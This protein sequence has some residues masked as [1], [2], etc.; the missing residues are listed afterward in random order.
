MLSQFYVDIGELSYKMHGGADVF[1]FAALNNILQRKIEGNTTLRDCTYKI[2]SYNTLYKSLDKEPHYSNIRDNLRLNSGIFDIIACQE[3]GYSVANRILKEANAQYTYTLHTSAV[4]MGRITTFYKNDLQLLHKVDGI[5]EYTDRKNKTD[6]RPFAIFLFKAKLPNLYGATDATEEFIFINLHNPHGHRP[7]GISTHIMA[8]INKTGNEAFRNVKRIIVAGDFNGQDI[9]NTING[10]RVNN[11][12]VLT[13]ED[14][15]QPLTLCKGENTNCSTPTEKADFI[16]DTYYRPLQYDTHSRPELLY[17]VF[18]HKDPSSD[19][20][21]LCGIYKR[22]FPGIPTTI[23][24]PV[25]EKIH[26]GNNICFYIAMVQLLRLIAPVQVDA[27]IERNRK[28]DICKLHLEKIMKNYDYKFGKTG[29]PA[30]YTHA[31]ISEHNVGSSENFLLASVLSKQLRYKI[32]G[33]TVD[34]I[35]NGHDDFQYL[36]SIATTDGKS[37]SAILKEESKRMRLSETSQFILFDTQRSVHSRINLVIDDTIQVD[38]NTYVLKAVIVYPGAHFYT[39]ANINKKWY[40]LNDDHKIEVADKLIDEYKEDIMGG[41]RFLL[42]ERTTAPVDQ[43]E[44][45]KSIEVKYLKYK[46]GDPKTDIFNSKFYEQFSDFTN[47]YL[48][49]GVNQEVRPGGSGTN[50]AISNIGEAVSENRD[51]KHFFDRKNIGTVYNSQYNELR[52]IDGDPAIVSNL[53]GNDKYFH[54]IAD[55]K[56]KIKTSDA[57]NNMYA[58]SVLFVNNKGLY[59]KKNIQGVYHIKGIN[60]TLLDKKH[61]PDTIP[62]VKTYYLRILQDMLG[63]AVANKYDNIAIHLA[64]VPGAIYQGTRTC[65]GLLGAVDEFSKD[66]LKSGHNIKILII[67][68]CDKPVNNDTDKPGDVNVNNDKPANNDTGNTGNVNV[69]LANLSIPN[70][71]SNHDIVDIMESHYNPSDKSTHVNNTEFYRKV[72]KKHPE[73]TRF[74]MTSRFN[75]YLAVDNAYPNNALIKLGLNVPLTDYEFN[76]S[77][78]HI[79]GEFEL[80]IA[81]TRYYATYVTYRHAEKQI[82]NLSGTVVISGIYHIFPI[83]CDTENVKII[84]GKHEKYSE[85]YHREEIIK[86]YTKILD[87]TIDKNVGGNYALLNNENIV[88]DKFSKDNI[89]IYLYSTPD[90]SCGIINAYEIIKE[91]VIQWKA[92]HES[93]TKDNPR[94]IVIII[95]SGII[96][97]TAIDIPSNQRVEAKYILNV[98]QNRNKSKGEYV[99]ALREHNIA[100]KTDDNVAQIALSPA[101]KAEFDRFFNQHRSLRIEAE[102]IIEVMTDDQK[103]KFLKAVKSMVR[104]DNSFI[105]ECLGVLNEIMEL[106]S[107][108]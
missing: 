92:K 11:R 60:W 39:Y 3:M 27:L 1:T 13:N 94:K 52:Y 37:V 48:T 99:D 22:D 26:N 88:A 63:R 33:N 56:Q 83:E 78:A 105:S 19:H 80:D 73:I 93:K 44:K 43:E 97:T 24:V 106:S 46:G 86:A 4:G 18:E 53:S 79:Y 55:E 100:R 69:D 108:L 15:L 71:K 35:N 28:V 6:R 32:T 65:E 38:N 29:D 42:Y 45:Q 25:P 36:H 59:H 54:I 30:D 2:L 31:L 107:K 23:N 49:N 17:K 67:A 87:Y 77:D 70:V 57:L 74:F 61:E 21:P 76:T 82:P 81:R 34:T 16:A 91:A 101:E 72:L 75:N 10:L 98:E 12:E 62:L 96:P 50:Q 7:S 103:R 40:K 20:V 5:F 66:F 68:D 51:A 9:D 102:Q 95:D 58:G 104:V 64:S 41:G 47:F 14:K 84:T 8:V 85:E 89:A 90:H